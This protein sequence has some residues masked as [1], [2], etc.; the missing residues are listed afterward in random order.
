MVIPELYRSYTNLIPN[1]TIKGKEIKGNNIKETYLTIGKE[2]LGAATASPSFAL[3]WQ[4][5][6]FPLKLL[7]MSFSK[8]KIAKNL[9]G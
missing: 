5:P 2:S 4:K 7:F 6:T 9:Q 1:Y 8:K 3:L